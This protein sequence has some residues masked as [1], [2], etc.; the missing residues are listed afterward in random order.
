[1]LNK[2]AA[3]LVLTLMSP[4]AYAGDSVW[5]WCKGTGDQGTATPPKRTYLGA[6]LLEHR[7][8][9]GDHRDLAVT[10]VYGDHVS[11]GAIIGQHAGE[12][13]GKPTALVASNLSGK[14]SVTFTGTAE[15]AK[16]MRSFTLKGSIDTSFGSDPKSKPIAY[17]AKLTCETLDDLAIGP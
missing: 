14:P 8:A 3:I 2:V 9:T 1:M 16:D 13:L 17:V 7:G 12:W 15:L 5:L 4:A 10:L 11:R 6:S